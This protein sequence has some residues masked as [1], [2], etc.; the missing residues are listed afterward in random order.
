MK[1]YFCKECEKEVLATIKDG[2]TLFYCECDG[3]ITNFAYFREIS[4][5]K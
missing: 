1:G 2:V 5:I 3:K 4:D